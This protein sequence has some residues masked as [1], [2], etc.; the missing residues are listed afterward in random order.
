MFINNGSKRGQD[1]RRQ[2]AGCIFNGQQKEH[3][4]CETWTPSTTFFREALHTCIHSEVSIYVGSSNYVCSLF[5]IKCWRPTHPISSFIFVTRCPVFLGRYVPILSYKDD[6]I[7]MTVDK[8]T[9]Y[10]SHPILNSEPT[11]PTSNH[12]RQ[13]KVEKDKGSS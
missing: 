10:L 1:K 9:H 5:K 2:L 11:Q 3:C 4:L 13:V 7:I 6:T 8:F 12:M